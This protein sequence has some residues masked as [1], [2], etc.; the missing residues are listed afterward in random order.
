M[1][2]CN[3]PQLLLRRHPVYVVWRQHVSLAYI[4]GV[5]SR[6]QHCIHLLMVTR[7]GVNAL[8][9]SILVNVVAFYVTNILQ[10]RCIRDYHPIWT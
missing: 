7:K 1:S 2:D 3:G 8:S 4:S 6:E 9:L 5:E 10:C